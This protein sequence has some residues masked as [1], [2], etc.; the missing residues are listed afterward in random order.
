[1]KTP[2]NTTTFEYYNANPKGNKTNDCV[3]RAIATATGK[4]WDEVFDALCEIAQKDKL[5][6][7][8]EKCYGKYLKSLGWKKVGQP[9]KADNKKYTAAEW[10]EKLLAYNNKQPRLVNVG[11]RHITCIKP[12]DGKYKVFDTWDCTNNCVGI[13]WLPDNQ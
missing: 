2:Q 9:R 7:N 10:C 1:M 5:M 8:D 11:C 3:V 12:I 4:S 13:S 6:P